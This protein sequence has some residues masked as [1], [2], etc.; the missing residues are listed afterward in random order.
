MP[1]DTADRPFKSREHAPAWRIFG[2]DVPNSL[3]GSNGP[4]TCQVFGRPN[5][6][7]N[8]QLRYLLPDIRQVGQ[9]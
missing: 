8:E 5:A 1:S 6:C 2:S 9:H 4:E 7:G 3:G